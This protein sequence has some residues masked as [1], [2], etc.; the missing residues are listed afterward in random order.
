MTA[1]LDNS[2][3]LKR[4]SEIQ[5][6]LTQVSQ[7]VAQQGAG[8]QQ[9]FDSAKGSLIGLAAQF[10]IGFSAVG[11]VKQ[12]AT[13][14]GQFQQLESS[15]TTLLGSEEKANTLMQQLTKTAA[16]TPFDLNGVAAAGKQ[17]LAYGV[18]ADQV[19]DKILQLGN[20][21]AGMNLGMDYMSMLYGTTASKDFMDTMD[22]KQHKGQGIPIEEAIASIMGIEKK[23][24]ADAVSNR[25]VTSKIYEA[26]IAQLAGTGGKFD[27]MMENQSKTITGQISN[28]EDAIDT[29]FND[30]GKSSEDIISDVLSGVSWV[31][32]N[33]KQ[34]AEA[35]G[36]VVGAYGMY[37]GALAATAAVQSA[38][39][40]S[41]MDALQGL[42]DAQNKVTGDE[43]LNKLVERGYLSEEEAK[44]L[45]DLRAQ[46]AEMEEAADKQVKA[47]EEQIK[48]A[49]DLIKEKNSEKKAAKEAVEAAQQKLDQ[50][51]KEGNQE[52]INAA[53]TE[54]NT[55]KQN[56]NNVSKEAAAARSQKKAASQALETAQT[57]AQTLATQRETVATNTMSKAKQAACLVGKQLTAVFNGIKAAVISNPLGAVAAAFTA[58]AYG[59]Y[60]VVTYKSDWEKTMD[61][62]NETIDKAQTSS[63]A[64]NAQLKVLTDRLYE[65]KKKMDAANEAKEKG[66]DTA[67]KSADA[68]GEE[69]EAT[70]DLATATKEYEDAKA[71]IIEQYGEYHKGLDTEIDKLAEENR[72]YEAIAKNVTKKF[73]AQAKAE[74]TNQINEQYGEQAGGS[75]KEVGVYAQEKIDEINGDRSLSAEAKAKL[76]DEWKTA[77]KEMQDAIIQGTLGAVKDTKTGLLKVTGVSDRTSE[78]FSEENDLVG[79]GSPD[80]YFES[81]WG[82]KAQ[83]I[84]NQRKRYEEK[85]AELDATYGSDGETKPTDKPET[86]IVDRD[87]VAEYKKKFD[88]AEAAYQKGL[89]DIASSN[90]ADHYYTPTGETEAKE[91][92]HEYIEGLKKARDQAKA[93]YDTVLGKEKSSSSTKDTTAKAKEE[94]AK[95]YKEQEDAQDAYA[96]SLMR[97]AK[98]MEYEQAQARIN[99]MDEGYEQT[100][101]QRELNHQKELDKIRQEGEQR[102]EEIVKQAEEEFERQEE[103]NAKLA[104]SK[105]QKYTKKTFDRQAFVSSQYDEN[106]NVVAGSAFEAADATTAMQLGNYNDQY[107]RDQAKQATKDIADL[108]KNWTEVYNIEKA[109]RTELQAIADEEAADAANKDL[110]ADERASRATARGNRAD[111]AL[112]ERNDAMAAAGFDN[113]KGDELSMSAQEVA[114]AT[115]AATVDPLKALL[116]A[117]LAEL[118]VLQA[119]YEA[120]DSSVSLETIAVQRARIKAL[121]SEVKSYEKDKNT[122]KETKTKKEKWQAI[123]QAAADCGA[124]FEE[125]GESMGGAAGEV[126]SYIGKVLGVASSIIGAVLS[127]SAAAE[128][129]IVGTSAAGTTA[130]K[131]METASVILAI[132]SAALQVAQAIASLFTKE[133]SAEKYEKAKA[134]YEGYMDVLDEVIDKQIELAETATGDAANSAMEQA[135]DYYQKAIDNSKLQEEATRKL[136]VTGAEAGASHTTHA[137]GWRVKADMSSEGWEQAAKAMGVSVST[138]KDSVGARMENLFSW[139]AE[140][141]EK[142][143][144]EAPLFWSQLSYEIGDNLDKVLEYADQTSELVNTMKEGL[145]GFSLDDLKSS[146]QD[147]FSDLE[148][149]ADDFSK[150]MAETLKDSIM[151]NAFRNEYSKELEDL[152]EEYYKKMKSG[153]TIT[154]EEYKALMDATEELEAKAAKKKQELAEE[155]GFD[156][157]TADDQEATYGG[158]EKMSEETGTELSGR[159]SAMYIVQSEHLALAQGMDEKITSACNLIGVQNEVMSDLRELQ[160]KGVEHLSTIAKVTSSIFSEFGERLEKIERYTK[161]LE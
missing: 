82:M 97:D 90:A 44:K 100:L 68:N 77:R 107:A 53:Q 110:T 134:M 76:I 70:D 15:F 137:Y 118:D 89:K 9:A 128:A 61:T 26:A 152:Y 136:G 117:A 94:L 13:V 19:N 3:Y 59:I 148:G 32:E 45:I 156:E 154:P 135:A 93:N 157:Y 133:S 103:I 145:L 147:F 41:E 79:F 43:Q 24:V 1:S 20:I 84:V 18:A 106:G 12:V 78:L 40:K 130:I 150:N 159:F 98:V 119:K 108:A 49:Q 11:F 58:V 80:A 158:Y 22:L 35:I 143:K 63:V 86:S 65:A 31:V 34:V 124:A 5:K 4:M 25:Q 50:A 87:I 27:G 120:G 54:L 113:T 37:K 146:F 71:Q 14:R 72:L 153:L 10:G 144:T 127:V 104:E 141:L 52:A 64:E 102:K 23:D 29:M 88:E 69:A 6:S 151:D 142:L 126:M 149:D 140:K 66:V 56:L 129:A 7:Q 47:Y 101:A 125:A 111:V 17:L 21:A 36:V 2:E 105:G 132:I 161:T 48:A 115:L 91:M 123:Q 74:A 57:Q 96:L 122:D 62:V 139:D 28:I 67:E 42:V 155:Y 73:V 38:S 33:Y 116:D 75:V 81:L 131:T 16:I 112:M 92:D 83:T 138:F 51:T 85:L 55:A 39:A 160:A 99:A 121:N 109:Y 8:M 60:K 95:L 114:D 30:I 46:Y